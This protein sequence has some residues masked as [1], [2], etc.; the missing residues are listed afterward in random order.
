LKDSV[1]VDHPLK[2]RL[3]GQHI[4]T[5]P[6]QQQ[7]VQNKL[8]LGANIARTRMTRKD[9]H[10]LQK[11]QQFSYIRLSLSNIPTA[12]S[13]FLQFAEKRRGLVRR[14]DLLR[15]ADMHRDQRSPRGAT[16]DD[17]PAAVPPRI[18][19]MLCDVSCPR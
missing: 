6:Q 14:S 7:L 10:S 13:E 5:V 3:L 16:T 1:Y 2:R 15:W 17:Q 11:E 4:R 12:L 8:P 18:P 19:I 9:L